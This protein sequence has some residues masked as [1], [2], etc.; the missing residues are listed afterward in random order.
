MTQP[1]RVLISLSARRRCRAFYTRLSRLPGF[2]LALDG[3]LILIDPRSCLLQTEFVS[4]FIARKFLESEPTDH[5][6]R[7]PF[8][9]PI[10][11]ALNSKSVSGSA[12]VL[13]FNHDVKTLVF[14]GIQYGSPPRRRGAEARIR[15]SVRPSICALLTPARVTLSTY[16]ALARKNSGEIRVR[17]GS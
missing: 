4:C 9:V 17:S 6:R 15:R 16:R 3:F 5:T 1:G 14:D 10:D 11:M 2:A 8:R 12:V 7:R 13:D